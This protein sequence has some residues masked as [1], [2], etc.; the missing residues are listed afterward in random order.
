MQLIVKLLYEINPL[1][2][3]LVLRLKV[4]LDRA[5][6]VVSEANTTPNYLSNRTILHSR[7]QIVVLNFAFRYLQDFDKIRPQICNHYFKISLY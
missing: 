3:N 7:F 5:I 1:V 6:G 4:R 2:C